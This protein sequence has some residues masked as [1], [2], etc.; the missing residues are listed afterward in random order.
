VVLHHVLAEERR[1][2]ARATDGSSDTSA[3]VPA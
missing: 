2:G 3:G 1:S